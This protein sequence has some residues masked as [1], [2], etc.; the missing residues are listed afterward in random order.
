[1]KYFNRH[2]EPDFLSDHA[3][4]W[5][6]QWSRLKQRNPGA[7]FQW[8]T[9]ER[10]RVN[11]KIVPLLARQTQDHCSY[12]DAYPQRTGDDTIDHFCP[13]GAPA[14][15]HLAYTWTNL[16]IACN[17]CQRSKMEDFSDKLL[18]PDA[19]DYAFE[20][21]FV[22]NYSTHEITP[23]P[24][25][26]EADKE[27]ALETIKIF[28][29]NAPGNLISRRHTL[30]RWTGLPADLKHLDDFPFRFALL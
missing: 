17:H 14:F 16:Y 28:N 9:H 23:N 22:Y 20:R 7:S 5:N 2:P 19:D 8:N 25:A 3:A 6:E 1:M 21:Y 30:E 13:K 15:H 11:Q 26:D 4:R 18:R 27:K 10:Q 24:A 12:C 29:F